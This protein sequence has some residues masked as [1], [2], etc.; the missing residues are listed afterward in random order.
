MKNVL[1]RLWQTLTGDSRDSSKDEQFE[2]VEEFSEEDHRKWVREL[3]QQHQAELDAKKSRE[4]EFVWCLVGN[5]IGEHAVGES[6]EIRRGTKH[7]SPGTKVYC[8]PPRWGDGYEKIYVIG[9][10]R[11]STRFIKVVI[12]SSMVTTW[13]I[14]KVYSNHIK[15]EMI[16]NNGWDETD[17]SKE[18]AYK[19]LNAIQGNDVK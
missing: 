1:A 2:E 9:R 5:I 11:K 8:F 13:R 16:R 7:F 10:P 3:N 18:R 6:K 19:L 14:Q 12:R 15:R 17:E 4:V